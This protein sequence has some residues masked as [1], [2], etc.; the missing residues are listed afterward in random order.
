MVNL[1]LFA[2]A[3]Q[4]SLLQLLHSTWFSWEQ[5]CELVVPKKVFLL[6]VW[7]RDLVASIIQSRDGPSKLGISPSKLGI[8]ILKRKSFSTQK[9]TDLVVVEKTHPESRVDWRKIKYSPKVYPENHGF[10]VRNLLFQWLNIS[11]S[12]LNCRGVKNGKLSSGS[13]TTAIS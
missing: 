10:Q 2:G 9:L 11:D 13:P 3:T 7:H 1:P 5:N 6:C 8:S 4:P 12:M